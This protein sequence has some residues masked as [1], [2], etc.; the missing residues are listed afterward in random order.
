[1]AGTAVITAKAQTANDKG[2]V[3]EA[4]GRIDKVRWMLALLDDI[5]DYAGEV[6]LEGDS[7]IGLKQALLDARNELQEARETLEHIVYSVPRLDRAR[8]GAD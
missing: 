6:H 5:T 8:A 3:A 4:L 2:I 7:V 1:M